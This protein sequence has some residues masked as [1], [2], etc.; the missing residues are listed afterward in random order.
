MSQI[1][2]SQ[3]SF[4]PL[5]TSAQYMYFRYRKDGDTLWIIADPNKLVAVDG[6]V[7][8]P[9]VINNILEGTKYN[10]SVATVNCKSAEYII[11]IT[12]PAPV[13]P[14]I[15]SIGYTLSN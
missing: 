6:T 12:T 3:V 2:I 1:V 8:P 15:N 5:P 10:V 11:D 7:N 14:S 9:I 4:N 13:C